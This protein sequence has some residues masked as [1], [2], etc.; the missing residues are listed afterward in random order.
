MKKLHIKAI[1]SS[2]ILVIF[3]L[4]TITGIGLFLAPSGLI[5]KTTD[6]TFLSMTKFQLEKFHTLTGFIFVAL[7]IVHFIMNL[8]LFKGEL[9]SLFRKRK[10]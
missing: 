1:L 6:W 3:I 10:K 4:V 5:A 8:S 2:T 9:K 7:I